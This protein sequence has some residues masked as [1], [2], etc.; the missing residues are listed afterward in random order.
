MAKKRQGSEQEETGGGENEE[1]IIVISGPSKE[2]LGK[3]GGK[4]CLWLIGGAG[5]L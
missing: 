3:G 1:I 5:P 2:I 4:L